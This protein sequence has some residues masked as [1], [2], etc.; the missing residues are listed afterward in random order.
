MCKT[1]IQFMSKALMMILLSIAPAM[2]QYKAEPA[3]APPSELDAAV[4]ATLQKEGVKVIAENGSVF[5]E[6]WVRTNMP[7]GPKLSEDNVSLVTVPHGALLG[8]I[9]F[10]GRGSERRGQMLKPGVYTLRFSF[11][12]ADG[13]HQGAAPQRDFLILSPA[14]IDKDPN[15]TPGFDALMD[16]SR[17]ASGTPHPASLSCWKADTDFKPGLAKE[18]ESDWVLHV[19]IGDT[20]VAI[21][22]AGQHAG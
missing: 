3:G 17:K 4:A 14:S 13:N 18:G 1:E 9:R 21:I 10:P 2:A 20:P 16:M 7:S 15:S 19:K 6:I 22:V 5:C 12:P 8:A 11:Y